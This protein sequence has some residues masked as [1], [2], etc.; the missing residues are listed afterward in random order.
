[1]TRCLL[2]Y[3]GLQLRFHICYHDRINHDLKLGRVNQLPV[4]SDT[5]TF[6]NQRF[7]VNFEL[8]G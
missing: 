8:S 1:M 6:I 3:R 2:A 7:N 5:L 4:C